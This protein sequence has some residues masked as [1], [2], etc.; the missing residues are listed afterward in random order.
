MMLFFFACAAPCAGARESRRTRQAPR[1]WPWLAGCGAAFGL[2][3]LTHGLTMWIFAGRD[4]FRPCSLSRP[5]GRP[6][7][8]LIGAFAVIYLPLDDPYAARV[9]QPPVGVAWY[10]YLQPDSRGARVP[11]CAPMDPPFEGRIA[12]GITG[13]KFR[14]GSSLNSTHLYY[15]LGRI[16]MGAH[17]LHRPAPCFSNARKTQTFRWAI[18]SMWLAAIAGMALTG[19]DERPVLAPFAPDVQGERPAH[20]FSHH[21]WPPIGL[22]FTLV[23]WSRLGINIRLVRFRFSLANHF[24]LVSG[25]P[26]FVSV[27]RTQQRSRAVAVQWPPYAPP[28]IA[29]L[30]DWTNEKEVIASDMPWAVAWYADRKSPVAADDD[31]GI[32]GS[33]RLQP[34]Q[35]WNRRPF[36]SPPVTHKPR[37]SGWKSSAGE[38]KEWSGFINPSGFRAHAQGF[39]AQGPFIPSARSMAKVSSMAEPRPAGRRAKIDA[40]HRPMNCS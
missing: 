22:A 25:A 28:I 7:R 36:I 23:M 37:V 30:H 2:L 16:A 14:R 5:A 8:V 15:S 17:V 19:M 40:P 29:M 1:T 39:S 3:A 13:R 20:P 33:Q 31:Q 34:A 10:A 12:P 11:S 35:W 4:R 24:F 6:P 27:H 9:R 26:F 21:S 32:H 18:L 38:Y